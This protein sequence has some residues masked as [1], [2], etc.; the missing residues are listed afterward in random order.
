M[1]VLKNVD[2]ENRVGIGTTSPYSKLEINAGADKSHIRI[3]DGSHN[4]NGST[5][6]Y[7]ALTYYARQD[8]IRR[9]TDPYTEGIG[10]NGGASASI[11]FTDRPG[12]YTYPTYTRGS[13]IVFHTARTVDD[14]N[15]VLGY[16]PRERMRITAEGNVGI[17]TT[18]PKSGLQVI[19][20]DGL[21][22]SG[23]ATTG[24]RTAVLRLGS[25]YT[26]NHDAY[27]AKITSTNNHDN[28]YNSDLRFF[29]SNGDNQS[30]NERMCILSNGNVGIGETN[31][32]GL[33]HLKT[34]TAVNVGTTEG[35]IIGSHDEFMAL[36]IESRGDTGDV[37]SISGAIKFASWANPDNSYPDVS[38]VGNLRFYVNSPGNSSNAYGAT[39]NT[40]VMSLAGNGNVGIGTQ[41]PSKKLEVIGDIK[42]DKILY[43]NVFDSEDDL[44][45]ASTYHGMFAHV[46]GTGRSYFSH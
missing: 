9:N 17:G 8:N 35:D 31:P 28:N 27:C 7:P 46:H 14:T 11:S 25:P 29:T 32:V 1:L 16:Y 18:T 39:P 40:M 21:T 4:G 13:D 15:S 36:K 45:S 19:N 12:T 3:A 44:P 20:D 37:N 10:A 6:L 38:P 5:F 30:A 33:V 24:V 43:S 42:A 41:T 2:G 26:S 34:T 22:I 23:T